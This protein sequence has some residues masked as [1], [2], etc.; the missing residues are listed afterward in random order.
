[1]FLYY[2]IKNKF[3]IIFNICDQVGFMR[4]AYSKLYP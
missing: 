3:G 2:E 4:N 1:M